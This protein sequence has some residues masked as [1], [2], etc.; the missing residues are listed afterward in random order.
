MLDTKGTNIP[1]WQKASKLGET[2][3]FRVHLDKRYPPLCSLVD[4]HS[5]DTTEYGEDQTITCSSLQSFLEEGDSLEESVVAS[6]SAADAGSVL[7]L[8]EAVTAYA[9]DNVALVKKAFYSSVFWES[10]RGAI[11]VFFLLKLVMVLSIF[12]YWFSCFFF[13]GV[14]VG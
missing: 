11:D 13:R 9:K 8:Q 7:A 2:V 12:L 14:K 10:R 1:I 4:L 5:N 6:P 3:F